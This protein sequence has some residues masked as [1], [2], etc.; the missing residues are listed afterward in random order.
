M[1]LPP[2][3]TTSRTRRE[4]QRPEFLA[5]SG[6]GPGLAAAAQAARRARQW[7]QNA[8]DSKVSDIETYFHLAAEETNDAQ[9]ANRCSRISQGT[10]RG[11][12]LRLRTRNHH[13]ARRRKR[14]PQRHRDHQARRRRHRIAGLG[15]DA[16][17]HVSALGR[18]KRVSAPR[19]SIRRP[20]KTR[21]SNPPPCGSK[22]KT[23]TACSHGESGVHRLMRISPFDQAARR[24][25]SFA[26]VFVIPEIDDR[27]EIVVKPED[28]RIDTFRAGRR[29]RPEREQGGNRRAHHAPAHRASSCS[30]R[31]SAASTRI[32]NS[33]MKVL[34]SRL[35]E[36]EIEKR[37]GETRK[38]DETKRD[39]SFGSQIRTYVHAAL[40][41]DQGPPHKV[42]EGRR[43]EGARWRPRSRSFAIIFSTAARL[44]STGRV[45]RR[46]ARRSFVWRA[47]AAC[48]PFNP[49][50]TPFPV[51]IIDTHSTRMLASMFIV[52]AK[53]RISLADL[54]S[55]ISLEGT[56]LAQDMRNFC[57][58][59]NR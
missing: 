20:A 25:T 16:A 48:L 30:A 7:P 57:L 11:R 29:R 3:E 52:I 1:T 40:P 58:P 54:P 49:D 34:R 44:P 37:H 56:G 43:P 39:I 31:T 53:V 46:M 9:R 13:A 10:R 45:C 15:R 32:A 24:H 35:Y 59:R 14:P 28:L 22:A 5:R 26:S 8:L 19:C 42:R 18:A 2:P 51:Q 27:I 55:H 33:A 17:A 21:A 23:P 50:L 12:Y 41:A 47:S 36:L 38:M 6:K 4:N